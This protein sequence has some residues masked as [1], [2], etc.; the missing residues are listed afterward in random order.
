MVATEKARSANP[1]QAPT[2][3][4]V[5]GSEPLLETWYRPSQEQGP[6]HIEPDP[7]LETTYFAQNREAAKAPEIRPD[8]LLQTDYFSGQPDSKKEPRAKL[9]DDWYG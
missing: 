2:R 3:P 5:L 6:G 9:A 8:P 7:L 4:S 1:N